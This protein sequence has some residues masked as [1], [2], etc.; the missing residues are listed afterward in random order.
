MLI[1][2]KHSWRLNERRYGALQ[3]LNK[4][5]TAEQV[6]LWRRSYTAV[7][8]SLT[9]D[10]RRHPRF[11]P[12]YARYDHRFLPTTESLLDTLERFLPLW[13][14]HIALDLR[15]GKN[16][17]IAAHGNS[18]RGL[19]NMLECIHNDVKGQLVNMGL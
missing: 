14:G 15:S 6:F 12:R 16:V 1:P 17:L 7:L 19:V 8:P 10:D 3:S 18:L 2:V 11:D 9:N 13:Q 4:Q 5:K